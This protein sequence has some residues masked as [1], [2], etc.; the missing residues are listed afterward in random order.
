MGKLKAVCIKKKVQKIKSSIAAR[1]NSRGRQTKSPHESNRNVCWREEHTVNNVRHAI[2]GQIVCPHHLVVTVHTHFT[3]ELCDNDMFALN[4]LHGLE[5]LEVSGQ[6]LCREHVVGEN[7][8]E[9]I[10]VLRL[11]KGIQCA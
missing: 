5:G 11:Q 4:R 8:N 3:A 7:V 6:H 9:L 1:T 2:A 10:L